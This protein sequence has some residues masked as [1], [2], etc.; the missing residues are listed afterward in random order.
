MFEVYAGKDLEIETNT[1]VDNLT[2]AQHDYT[3]IMKAQTP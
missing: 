3:D 1:D 2:I